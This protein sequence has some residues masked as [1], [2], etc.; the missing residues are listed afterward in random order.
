MIIVTGL[1]P[2]QQCPTMRMSHHFISVCVLYAVMMHL[3]CGVFG[4]GVVGGGGDGGGGV[5]GGAGGANGGRQTGVTSAHAT[6]H[7]RHKRLIRS[8]VSMPYPP[9]L[10]G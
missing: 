5:S 3:K 1:L 9:F 4:G 6:G 2:H 10:H 8:G 7:E